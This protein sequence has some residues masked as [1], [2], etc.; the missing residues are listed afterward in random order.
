MPGACCALRSSRASGR[1]AGPG[2]AQV[3]GGLRVTEAGLAF[4]AAFSTCHEQLRD[5]RIP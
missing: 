1:R 4:K 2:V 3:R 5:S